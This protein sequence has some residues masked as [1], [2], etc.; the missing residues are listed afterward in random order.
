[1]T[2]KA[3]EDMKSIVRAEGK[4]E[5]K[6]EG[7]IEG[8]VLIAM[9]LGKSKEETIELVCKQYGIDKETVESYIAKST[10]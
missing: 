6:S 2:C 7:I 10:D 1:M 5:G 3:I 9:K 8:S 4:A